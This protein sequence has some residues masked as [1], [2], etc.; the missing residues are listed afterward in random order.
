MFMNRFISTFF[1]DPER[2]NTF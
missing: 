2:S 1:V